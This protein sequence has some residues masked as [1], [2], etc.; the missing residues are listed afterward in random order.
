MAEK[1][2]N[3][4]DNDDIRKAFKEK[5]SMPVITPKVNTG[6]T[7]LSTLA[8]SSKKLIQ[9]DSEFIKEIYAD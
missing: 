1:H 6:K 2:F 4:Y 8:E 3:Q 7:T 9:E 5:E